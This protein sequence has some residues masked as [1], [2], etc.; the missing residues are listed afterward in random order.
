MYEE[1][2]GFYFMD[3][4]T[5]EEFRRIQEREQAI[6]KTCQLLVALATDNLAGVQHD[7]NIWW[8]KVYDEIGI[9]RSA[10]L[11]VSGADLRVSV[12]KEDQDATL[13]S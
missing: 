3:H 13:S 1:R 10:P 4:E 9:D 7:Y 8:N 6:A 2:D 11:Q 12:A 5:T